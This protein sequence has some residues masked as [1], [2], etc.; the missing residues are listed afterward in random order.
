MDILTERI[1]LLTFS[2]PRYSESIILI[3]VRTGL[4]K[5]H[6]LKLEKLICMEPE[7]LQFS[8]LNLKCLSF[9]PQ[10]WG[11]QTNQVVSSEEPRHSSDTAKAE[12]R[13]VQAPVFSF[14]SLKS[15]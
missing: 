6:K 7:I 8:H 5:T 13:K 4:Y 14:W 2:N 11:L 12:E 1:C 9:F 3:T 10:F 15:H